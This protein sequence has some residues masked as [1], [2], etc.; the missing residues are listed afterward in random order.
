M[1]GFLNPRLPLFGY[2]HEGQLIIKKSQHD[3]CFQIVSNMRT[4]RETPGE[5]KTAGHYDQPSRLVWAGKDLN[6]RRLRRQ[7]YSLLPLAAWVPTRDLQ[8]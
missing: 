6:L 7:I 8:R 4:A 3:Q 5:R 1:Q 2:V